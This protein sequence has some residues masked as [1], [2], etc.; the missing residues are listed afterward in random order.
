MSWEPIHKQP[1]ATQVIPNLL[2]YEQGRAIFSWE[3]RGLSWTD[4]RSGSASTLPMRPWI[5]M[6]WGRGGPGCISLGGERKR[7]RRFHLRPA[8]GV[9]KPFRQCS[10]E[11]GDRQ[12]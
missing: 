9:V 3:K 12:E 2:D 8:S 11:V 5:A 1:R 6:P 4:F 7:P 10:P